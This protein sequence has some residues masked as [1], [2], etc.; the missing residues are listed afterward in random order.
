M[1]P[2]RI[3]NIVLIVIAIL[4]FSSLILGV[5]K[6]RNLARTDL[7]IENGQALKQ[8]VTYFK[9]DTGRYPTSVEVEDKGIML[10]YLTIFPLVNFPT[11][12]CT[13]NYS[14]QSPSYSSYDLFICLPARSGDLQVGWNKI[15]L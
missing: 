10:D 15:G 6:G 14:Y 2:N 8:V 13:Q 7:F 3:Q 9:N 4:F 11:K 1:T 5:F 12:T